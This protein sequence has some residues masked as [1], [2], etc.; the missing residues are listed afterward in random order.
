MVIGDGAV[1]PS[2]AFRL[3]LTNATG[4]TI[5]GTGMAT[6]TILDAVA[7]IPTA[8]EW[9]LMALAGMLALLGATPMRF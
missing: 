6:V 7:L 5:S 1:E 9:V 8:S 2:D 3:A 4:A